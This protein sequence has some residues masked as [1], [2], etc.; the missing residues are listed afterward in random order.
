MREIALCGSRGGR[1]LVDNSDYEGV[2][3]YKWYLD[4]RGYP[5]TNIRPN[6]KKRSISI[7]LFLL[8]HA[9]GLHIDHMDGNKLN[10]QRYNLRRCTVSQNAMNRKINVNNK[11]GFRGVSWIESRNKWDV[12]ICKDSKIIRCGRFLLLADAV[13]A[14]ISARKKYH[15]E[16]ARI[17]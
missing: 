10:N 17:D 12:R 3:L 11:S 5:I 14:S 7:H 9:R 13:E 6:G 4:K 2:I 16:F 8:G 15:G 1:A